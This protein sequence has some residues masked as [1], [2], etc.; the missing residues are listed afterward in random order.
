MF[1]IGGPE[2]IFIILL[3][4]I[5]FGPKKIPEIAQMVGKG[6][7]KMKMAQSQLKDQIN[8]IQNEL[9]KSTNTL[10]KEIKEIHPVE[11]TKKHLNLD[12]KNQAISHKKDTDQ[13]TNIEKESTK[14]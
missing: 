8:E 2:L 4:I 6:L 12:Y 11:M 9:E 1:D 7:Q 5:L 3:I 13:N 10:Q 14:K